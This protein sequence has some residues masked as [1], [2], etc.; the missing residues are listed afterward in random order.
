MTDTTVNRVYEMT[1]EQYDVFFNCIDCG[2]N[3]RKIGEY[4][5]V[6]DDVW[7]AAG[8]TPN[9]TGVL[10]SEMLCIGCLEKRIK[11]RLRPNDFPPVE[12]NLGNKSPRLYSRVFGKRRRGEAP[13][14][15]MIHDG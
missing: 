12:A 3:T 10:T 7:A 6:N 1:K 11:R 15:E 5:L 9:V 13:R 4:Y 2:V 14:K 8:G